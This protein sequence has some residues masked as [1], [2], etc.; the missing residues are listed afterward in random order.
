MIIPKNVLDIV[1]SR[2]NYRCEYCHYPEFLSTAPLTIDHIFPKSLGGSDSLNNLALACRRCN[3]RHYNFIV[4]IDLE[5]QQE[6]PLFNPR[7]QRWSEHFIW[8]ADGT[9]IIG[10][11]SVGRA[12]CHRLDLNDKRRKDRF[13]QR[14][15]KLWKQ[16]GWHPPKEDPCLK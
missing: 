5:T 6:V 1:R 12:T 3:E 16:G 10:L 7:Q 9:K 14:S 11:T 2:A 8:T 13:I 4:G 15:R